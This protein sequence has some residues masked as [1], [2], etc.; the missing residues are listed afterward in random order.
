MRYAISLSIVLT[1]P[2]LLLG[3][4][5]EAAP[6][7][8]LAHID[9]GGTVVAADVTGATLVC[10]LST[11]S[12]CLFD[13]SQPNAP[14][15]RGALTG[16]G[17]ITSVAAWGQY[18]YIGGTKLTTVNISNV[19]SP[20]VTS[21]ITPSGAISSLVVSGGRLFAAA[22]AK[23]ALVYDLSAPAT[24]A[25]LGSYV[26]STSI[27][28]LGVLGSQVYAVDGTTQ[29]RIV[30]L[31]QPATPLLLGSITLPSV[32]KSIFI[33]SHYAY[34]GCVDG[35]MRVVDL[36]WPRYYTIGTCYVGETIV[37]LE[38]G[39]GAYVVAAGT[40]KLHAISVVDHTNPVL[41]ESLS[42][43]GTS[44]GMA[45]DARAAYIALGS[46]GLDIVNTASYATA[47]QTLGRV[48]PVAAAYDVA[49]EGGIG[50]GVLGTS[51]L[52]TSDFT[53]L[54]APVAL[55]ALVGLGNACAVVRD[56]QYAYVAAAE[57]GL[58]VI[59]IS[60]AS[61]PISVGH[62]SLPGSASGVALY[63]AAGGNP[64]VVV[65]GGSSGVLVVSLATPSTPMLVGQYD[66][67]GTAVHTVV[68]GTKAYVADGTGGV[69]VLNL[70]IPSAPSLL[71]SKTLPGPVSMVQPSASL[72][73]AAVQGG[74]VYVLNAAE[75]GSMVVLGSC[76][77]PG[78]D[79]AVGG[80]F[81][82]FGL[83]IDEPYVLV[84]DGAAGVT[85]VDVSN[86]AAPYVADNATV[87]GA[88]HALAV[89]GRTT[90]VADDGGV[91]IV[92]SG[93]YTS[94]V[95]LV[96]RL[97][98]RGWN[99]T[100][101]VRVVDN[102]L[103]QCDG[104]AGL[105]IF[106]I[107][108]P[109]NPSLLGSIDNA[110]LTWEQGRW[111]MY[112][113]AYEAP[114]AFVAARNSGVLVI[115]ISNP[116]APAL[117]TTID[118]PDMASDIEVDGARLFVADRAGGLLLYDVSNRSAP[119][120]VSAYDTPSVLYDEF[121]GLEVSGNLVYAAAYWMGLVV[122]DF[123]TPTAPVAAGSLRLSPYMLWDVKLRGD[124]A[125]VVGEGSG[126]Q[127]IDCSDLGNME[128]VGHAVTPD[129]GL[130][131]NDMP[132]FSVTV[133]G[134]C[135][136][137]GDGFGGLQVV[138]ITNVFAPRVIDSVALPG[139]SWGSGYKDGYVYV[140]DF[141]QGVAVVDATEYL[142][143]DPGGEGE[144]EGEG[145][146][147]TAAPTVTVT[148]PSDGVI[149]FTS[150]FTLTA[151]I[152][153][154]AAGGVVSSGLD[155]AEIWVDEALLQTIP[156]SGISAH[157]EQAICVTGPGLYPVR[158]YAYDAAGNFSSTPVI[159]VQYGMIGD[160]NYSG[161]IDSL[162][163]LLIN[164]IYLWGQ[165]ALNAYLATIGLAPVDARLADIDLSGSVTQWDATLLYHIIVN[166]KTAV[167]A[168]LAANSLPLAH[169]GEA[170]PR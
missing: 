41:L 119:V 24:P 36:A 82:P 7:S 145:E 27:S 158:V 93:V 90:L 54:S 118:T 152:A 151:D 45:T 117:V 5:A 70:S 57:N 170:L 132:P 65:S 104:G 108:E 20:S 69:V 143:S 83:S 11:G 37:G 86:P 13:V 34:V 106:D 124:Y 26:F 161:T 163:A 28:T 50:L 29:L 32:A 110:Y 64:Y 156:L 56:G 62:L 111:N 43:A 116:A 18:A 68:D 136:F 99:V 75:L 109:G 66:T 79:D 105:R 76:T 128:V 133:E 150:C 48:S 81:G 146:L 157:V 3:V 100:R 1:L 67:A 103:F 112:A 85:A 77:T 16:L 123:S 10:V 149:V 135:A 129:E 169:S 121:L 25:F 23:G 159:H 101:G 125:Y 33:K 8:T 63:K 134:N 52:R 30:D 160:V 115:D 165:T 78:S 51:G 107:S 88:C 49:I 40:T 19:T 61:A 87:T 154:P 142:V 80:Q 139:Y 140:G 164:Y 97:D 153:D 14:V 6:L 98:T 4:S 2:C 46:S 148:S 168:Y 122:V 59:D 58:Y 53:N 162:D 127:I 55:G 21:T 84:A 73:Y 38:K 9:A 131:P 113:V 92:D 15:Q 141:L 44:S 12:V 120:F 17:T 102:L 35:R 74:G 42:V 94:K 167:N 166:G 31:S 147:D 155:H 71:G 60:V 114:Y 47:L 130:A 91:A 95:S 22:G 89:S 72:L 39:V 144:G 126:L 138:D 96:A 137:V